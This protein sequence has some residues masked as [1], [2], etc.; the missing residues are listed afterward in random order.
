MANLELVVAGALTTVQD[1]GR[2]GFAAKGYPECGAADQYAMQLANVLAGNGA[3]SDTAVLE[4]TLMGASVKA[5]EAVL[6]A[7]AGAIC[8]PTVNGAA[9]PMFAPILLKAGDL[10]A[11]G[12]CKTGLRSYLAVY[13]GIAVPA[14][15]G[16][17]ATDTKCGIGGLDGRALQVGDILPL[18]DKAC[19]KTAEKAFAK[20]QKTAKKHKFS[21][22]AGLTEAWL[23]QSICKSKWQGGKRSPILRVVLGPQDE[24]FTA[25]GIA[26]FTS[27]LYPL[28]VDC[29]RMACKLKGAPIES[30]NGSDIIS[31]G[32]VAGSIQVASDGQPIV[33]LADHQTTGGYAKI[34]TVIPPDVSVLAQLRPGDT[35]AFATVSAEEA[36][37]VCRKQAKKLEWLEEQLS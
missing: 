28:T 31:D 29:N 3:G 27:T 37:D 7:I 35:V 1:A 13:G 4:C 5:T 34:A 25:A 21:Q 10:L 36:V 15:M 12:A 19:G 23:Q 30:V 17:R 24:A 8:T 16:S 32:I 22:V 11:L 20:L 9:V 6:V 26:T 33:M 2:K 14:V 18:V